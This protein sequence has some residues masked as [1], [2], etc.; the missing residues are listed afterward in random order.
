MQME[1][2]IKESGKMEKPMEQASLQ[3]LTDQCMKVNGK[4]ISN[5][6]MV[7]NLGTIIRSNLQENLQ[8]VKKLE[9]EDLSLKAVTMKEIL[10]MVNSM[11]QES[12]TLPI[13]V[14]FMKVI[15]EIIT[16]KEKA[17]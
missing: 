6:D 17:L 14:V 10:L 12:I 2:Y 8:K 7:L 13:Q 1:T 9:K 5:M 15:L 4:T 3:I 16:W 11:E